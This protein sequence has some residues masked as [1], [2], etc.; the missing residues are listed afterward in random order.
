MVGLLSLL[1]VTMMVVT[2]SEYNPVTK[3]YNNNVE[4]TKEEETGLTEI[5]VADKSFK[6]CIKELNYDD[7]ND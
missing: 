2:P 5:E 6:L 4:I 1:F 3:T 7:L